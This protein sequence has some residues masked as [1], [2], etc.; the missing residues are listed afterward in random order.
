[1]L[2]LPAAPADN[3]RYLLWSTDGFPKMLN[4]RSSFEPRF[5]VDAIRR[6]RCFPDEAS[7]AYL[8]K[9]GVRAVVVHGDQPGAARPRSCG[10]P[11]RDSGVRGY[12]LGPLV[13]SLIEDVGAPAGPGFG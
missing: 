10:P 2:Q 4:G 7:I 11:A 1:M 13:V 6:T 3:R 9:A 8:R 12:R 5:F